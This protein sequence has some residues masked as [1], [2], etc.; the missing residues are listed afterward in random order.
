MYLQYNKKRCSNGKQIHEKQVINFISC[1]EIENW[2][3]NTQNIL[4][5]FWNI[6]IYLLKCVSN[7]FESSF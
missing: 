3:H 6:T 2:Y 5:M 7:I 4:Q 1:Q